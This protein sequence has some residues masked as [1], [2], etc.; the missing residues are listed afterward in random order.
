MK[1]KNYFYAVLSGLII[2]M[3]LVA[4]DDDDDETPTSKWDP[5]TM[6]SKM[7]MAETRGFILNEGSYGYNNAHLIYFNYLSDEVNSNDVYSTQNGMEIGDT[8]Q[9]I[10]EYNGNIYMSV[11]N[12]NYIVK[13]NGVGIR[14]TSISFNDYNDLGDIRFMAASGGYIYVTSYG[15]YVSKLDAETLEYKGSVKVG[16]NPEEITIDDGYIYCVNSGWGYDN[17]MSII[18]ESSFNTAENVE[19]FVNPQAVIS[20]DNTIVIQGFGGEYLGDWNYTY[21][22]AIY[23]KTSKTYKEICKG[24][25]IAGYGDIVYILYTETDYSTSPYSG[26]TEVYS[27]NVKTGAF[28]SSPLDLPDEAK[29]SCTY[30]ISINQNTGDIYILATNYSW[31]DGTIYHFSSDGKYQKSFSS[32]GQNPKKIVFLNE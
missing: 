14:Q 7:E 9:D 26:T 19:I 20:V 22:V 32:Y 16:S 29:T 21:P 31:S 12:S 15:G 28:N 6:G 13:L 25:D 3:A 30:G 8:G 27:Y 18:S 11:Y 24:T 1:L 10:I 2:S 23:D 4:C 17:T 5:S